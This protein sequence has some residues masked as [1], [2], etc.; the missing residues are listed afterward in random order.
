MESLVG[1]HIRFTFRDTER[2]CGFVQQSSRAEL[3]VRLT[4]LDR[5]A[6]G[7]QTINSLVFTFLH[8]FNGNIKSRIIF[9][10]TKSNNSSYFSTFSK[11]QNQGN[12]F[13][14][15]LRDACKIIAYILSRLENWKCPPP[16]YAMNPPSPCVKHPPLNFFKN[17]YQERPFFV[18][19]SKSPSR[20]DVFQKQTLGRPFFFKN[21]KLKT[22]SRQGFFFFLQKAESKNTLWRRP[23]FQK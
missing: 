18:F 21:L 6:S 16:C 23:F 4:V 8:I 7:N 22:P 20:T 10:D 1:T 11:F 5:Q 9:F 17:P 19:F 3:V 13:G 12:A 14:W 2:Y 15:L